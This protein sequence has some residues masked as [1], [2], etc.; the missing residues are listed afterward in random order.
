MPGEA[1]YEIVARIVAQ[2]ASIPGTNAVEK[3]LDRLEKRAEGFGN[4]LGASFG[5]AMAFLG[6]TAGIGVAVKGVVSLNSEIETATNGMA[7]LFSAFTGAP[8]DQSL[9][10]AKGILGDL[11]KDAKAGVGELTNYTEGF[12]K[13]FGAT[14]GAVDDQAVRQ[15][16]RNALAAGFALR[17]NEGLALA[18]MDIAQALS[19]GVSRAETPIVMTALQSI[20]MSAE[21]FNKLDPAKK[22]ETLN[23]AFGGFAGGVELMGKSWDA[24]FSTLLDNI[25]ELARTA[26][27]PLFDRWSEKLR[28]INEW[29]AA[30]EEDLADVVQV[31]GRRLLDLWDQL[32]TKAGIYAGIVV[33]SALA[34]SLAPG[35]KTAAGGIAAGARFVGQAASAS[36]MVGVGTMAS[37]LGPTAMGAIQ[38]ALAA[39]GATFSTVVLPVVA[40]IGVIALAIGGMYGALQ[41]WSGLMDALLASIAFVTDALGELFGAFGSLVGQGSL[42]NIIGGALVGVLTAM[43]FV[44]GGLVKA[45]ALFVETLGLLLRLFGSGA[46]MAYAAITGD[47]RGGI[48][49]QV[50]GQRA[51]DEYRMRAGGILGLLPQP[52]EGA[53]DGTGEDGKPTV[54]KNVTN[55]GTVNVQVKAEV[56]EDPA[57][58]AVA[59]NEV[60]GNLERYSRQPKRPVKVPR[61]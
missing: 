9:G 58:V 56:N 26:T 57:R 47:V 34:P 17:G 11:R 25:R 43:L 45:A 19:G 18:P 37:L 13:I 50:E 59:F 32:I 36:K 55:I 20:G 46:K 42:L 38:A 22:V 54:P 39:V 44:F 7:T 10:R 40:I 49:A 29:F 15:L 8:I 16:T 2:D 31:W 41:E 21:K 28:Q 3:R 53:G 4:V 6:G 24:Q 48:L 30:H 5:K 33:G 1:D 35:A 60:L 12:Q 51:I 23:K 27:K 52:G 14:G 61:I